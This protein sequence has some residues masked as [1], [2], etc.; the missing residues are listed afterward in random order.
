MQFHTSRQSRRPLAFL[1]APLLIL[2][3][4]SAG[5]STSSGTQAHTGPGSSTGP[6]TGG[7]TATGGS[8]GS[9][10][11]AGSTPAVPAPQHA[12]AWTQYD[13][14]STRTPQLWASI[15][16]G[17]PYQVTHL[18]PIT[19]GCDT[20]IAW[21]L[22]VFSPDLTHI[23]ASIGSFNCGDGDLQGPVDIINASSGTIT[24]VP[25]ANSYDRSSERTDGWLNNNT[26]FFVNSAGLFTYTLG[27]GSPTQLPGV[28]G[29]D[30]AVLRGSTLFWTQVTYASGPKN[31]TST[32]HRYDMSTH[33]ALAGSISLGQVHMCECSPGDVLFQGWDVS[34]NGSHVA[35]QVTTPLTGAN[36]GIASSH[37]YYANADGT[38]ASQ[39]AEYMSTNA[40][41][42]MQISPNGQLVAFTG[43]LP[44]PSVITA[45]VTS[46]GNLSD[47]NFHSY[48]PNA[49]RYPVWKWDSSSFWAPNRSNGDFESPGTVALYYYTVGS[50]S[51]VVG[52]SGGFNPW[53]TIA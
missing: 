14:A 30:E 17:T 50:A 53:Y 19:D 29:A 11:G 31:W 47:P 20:Q 25:G 42:G 13:H 51:G 21:G 24:A 10:P 33:T 15:N 39:I 5:C 18:A 12:F 3:L 46:P 9:G 7:G 44:S 32:L 2:L 1:L 45:S 37:I 43:A 26:I 16:G 4:F 41:A 28:T 38:G 8:S 6:S 22:P 40:T 23:V 49:D 36:G 34:P 48:T 52:V 35:Y 27:A